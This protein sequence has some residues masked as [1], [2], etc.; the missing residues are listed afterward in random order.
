MTAALRRPR[1][2]LEHRCRHSHQHHFQR[3]HEAGPTAKTSHDVARL[4]HYLWLLSHH[5]R[6]SMKS[7][8]AAAI[9]GARRHAQARRRP[10][11][12]LDL[13][14]KREHRSKS[15]TPSTK[16]SAR[17][18]VPARSASRLGLRERE[19]CPAASRSCCAIDTVSRDVRLCTTYAQPHI[20]TTSQKNATNTHQS[21][22]TSPAITTH[23]SQIRGRQYTYARASSRDEDE[24]YRQSFRA[25]SIENDVETTQLQ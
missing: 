21:P 7:W 8:A 6:G 13:Q 10:R 1:S 2:H 3:R 22:T 15:T 20:H 23:H 16:E 19:D 25:Q 12:P 5:Q 24:S 9:A 11:S 18:E 14:Q 4:L 17:E